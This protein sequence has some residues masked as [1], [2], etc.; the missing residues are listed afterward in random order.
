MLTFPLGRTFRVD[1]DVLILFSNDGADYIR[2]CHT[3]RWASQS[4]VYRASL[5]EC[6]QCALN[7]DNQGRKRY[8]AIQARLMP[9]E[10]QP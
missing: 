9:L 5:P 1:G 7:N 4:Y 3:H 10:A 2:A 8:D 6:P